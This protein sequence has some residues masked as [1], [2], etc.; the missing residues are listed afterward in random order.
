MQLDEATLRDAIKQLE[1]HKSLA[2]DI[3]AIISGTRPT[4]AELESAPLLQRYRFVPRSVPSAVGYGIGH[5]RLPD[6]PVKT[7]QIFVLDPDLRWI[8][9]LSRFYRLGA[10]MPGAATND[11]LEDGK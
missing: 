3:A 6:G 10:Q 1:L 2:K 9:T 4:R 8:R 11:L 7:S 5:P